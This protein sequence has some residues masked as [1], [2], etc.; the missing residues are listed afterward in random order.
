MHREVD[1]LPVNAVRDLELSVVLPCL[2]EADTLEAC[3]QM[4]WRGL[5]ENNIEGEVVVADNGSTDASV[6]IARRCGARVVPVVARGYGSALMAGIE[7]ARGRFIVMGDADQSYD[8]LE[9]PRFVAKLREGFDLVQG[10]R[11]P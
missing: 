8:F 5:R 4:A 7:A 2:N 1:E 6:E 11:L 9:A 10:C 3:L